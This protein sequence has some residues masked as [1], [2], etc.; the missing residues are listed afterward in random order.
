MRYDN[1]GNYILHVFT[2]QFRETVP[3]GGAEAAI[4][5]MR[6]T[7]MVL[8]NDKQPSRHRDVGTIEKKPTVK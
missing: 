2:E 7:D 1:F 6:R 5:G 4:P 8:A 3:S